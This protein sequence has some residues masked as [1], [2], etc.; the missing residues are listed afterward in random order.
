MRAKLDTQRFDSDY[1]IVELLLSGWLSG[2]KVATLT[3]RVRYSMRRSLYAGFIA[4]W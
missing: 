2:F 1:P 3:F 4:V